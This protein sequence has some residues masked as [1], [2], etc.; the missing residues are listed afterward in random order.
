MSPILSASEVC[1]G[2]EKGEA[3]LDST[4][5]DAVIKIYDNFKTAS[6]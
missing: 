3:M 6:K 2:T 1:V 4:G 5:A